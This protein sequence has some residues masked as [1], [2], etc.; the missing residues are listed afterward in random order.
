MRANLACLAAIA[1]LLAAC[2]SGGVTPGAEHLGT[3]A[4][5]TPSEPQ[6]TPPPAE[7]WPGPTAE[8]P[9]RMP[10]TAP[11]ATAAPPVAPTPRVTPEPTLPPVTPPWTLD[12]SIALDD[13][14]PTPRI[15]AAT[16]K[17]RPPRERRR[18]P[19]ER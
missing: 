16:H 12:G 19:R 6:G 15:G 5:E 17:Q 3:S 13:P 18:P 7:T 8:A 14:T 9:S 2:G 11:A 10:T 1:V 4:I